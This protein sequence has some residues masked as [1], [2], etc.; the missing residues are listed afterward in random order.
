MNSAGIN[1]CDLL[2]LKNFAEETFAKKSKNREIAKLQ[3]FLPLKH[4]FRLTHT[5]RREL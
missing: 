3:R 1:Y 5:T 4:L 2:F